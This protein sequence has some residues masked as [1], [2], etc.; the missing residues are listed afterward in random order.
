MKHALLSPSSS[1]RWLACPGSVRANVDKPWTQNEHALLGT[2][3]HALLELCLRLDAEPTDFTGVL[4]DEGLMPIDEEM[5]DSVG[6]ALDFVKSYLA[7][8]PDAVVRPEREVHM[9]PQLGLK[10]LKCPKCDGVGRRGAKPSPPCPTCEGTGAVEVCWGTSDII[11]DNHPKECVVIDY[12]HGIGIVVN[13][14]NNSQ[15]L[16]YAAGQRQERGRYRRYRKVVIQPR[17]K[18]RKPV[19]EVTLTD[20]DLVKW[21]NT[22]AIPGAQAALKADAPRIPGEHCRYCHADGK[23]GAQ[24][25]EVQRAAAEEFKRPDPKGVTPDDISRALTT[26]ASIERIGKA[27]KEHAIKL[28]HAGVKVPGWEKDWTNA[29]RLWLDEDKVLK[30]LQGKFKLEKKECYKIEVLSPAQAE[31]VLKTKKLWPKKPRGS[32]GE[33]FVNPFHDVV[34][35]TER[36]PSISKTVDT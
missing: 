1:H 5:A 3:A 33:D 18:G 2:T 35:Y 27:I 28:V 16:L 21:I 25:V 17:V 26:L 31:D 12:K 36:N 10:K 14:K 34:G 13:V 20:T 24:Y 4:L 19:Q 29:R 9:D 6:Y 22:T 23:C 7:D 30:L 15:L 8:N 32:A 11:I